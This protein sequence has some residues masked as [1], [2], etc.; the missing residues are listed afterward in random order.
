M[1]LQE[2][3]KEFFAYL[4]IEKDASSLTIVS[5]PP[6]VLLMSVYSLPILAAA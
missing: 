2:V 1:D 3:M 4:T 6:P 5:Y